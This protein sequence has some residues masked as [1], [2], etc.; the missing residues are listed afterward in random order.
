MTAELQ[1]VSAH[2]GT[3]QGKGQ[4]GASPKLN[5]SRCD[6]YEQGN[7]FTGLHALQQ[8]VQPLTPSTATV[9]GDQAF[10]VHRNH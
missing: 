1:Q 2:L 3:T 10:C 8:G 9:R 5:T 6:C 7:Y 4:T